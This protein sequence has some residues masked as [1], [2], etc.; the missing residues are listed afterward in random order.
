[1]QCHRAATQWPPGRNARGGFSYRVIFVPFAGGK[2]D[3]APVHAA[4]P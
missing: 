3:G 4:T 1:M 2:P